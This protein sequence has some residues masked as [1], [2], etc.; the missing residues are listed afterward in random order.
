MGEFACILTE[1]IAQLIGL[2]Q[3]VLGAHHD[4]VH[5]LLGGQAILL[6]E[7]VNTPEGF[8]HINSIQ[9]FQCDRLLS[10][11]SQIGFAQIAKVLFDHQHC[12]G[13]GVHAFPDTRGV[14]VF[15][16]I[17]RL[18]RCLSRLAK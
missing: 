18:L 14:H 17:C 13:H 10:Q 6:H 7:G 11:V 4:I 9:F 1:V 15:N 2:I 8:I 5:S 12:I 3:T 16:D